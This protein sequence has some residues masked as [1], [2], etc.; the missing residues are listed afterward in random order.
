MSHRGQ[1]ARE[2]EKRHE[3]YCP[4]FTQK[5]Q[6]VEYESDNGQLVR[7]NRWISS[8][9]KPCGDK[10]PVGQRDRKASHPSHYETLSGDGSC[11][12]YFQAERN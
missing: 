9:G 7:W 11:G 6:E 4:R 8:G 1:F 10:D 2:T 12:G 5:N 3:V